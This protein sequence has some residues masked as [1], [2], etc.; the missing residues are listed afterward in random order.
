[1]SNNEKFSVGD[2]VRID[3][4][5]STYHGFFGEIFKTG[6]TFSKVTIKDPRFDPSPSTEN[7]TFTYYTAQ[8]I[9]V[10]HEVIEVGDTV[11]VV[12]A[13]EVYWNGTKGK[14]I[15][16]DDATIT[17]V[18]DSDKFAN[19]E[20]IHPQYMSTGARFTRRKF[21][22]IEAFKK[23]NQTKQDYSKVKNFG[24]F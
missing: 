3:C 2:R 18:P 15:S 8:L 5:N 7:S 12:D 16:F 11:M 22:K 1:M 21:V 4:K 24:I 14:V 19:G 9:P 10:K 6:E 13:D 17:F 20:H 23:T